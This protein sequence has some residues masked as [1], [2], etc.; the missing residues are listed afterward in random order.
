MPGCSSLG[1][2]LAKIDALEK[3]TGRAMYAADRR[4][5]GMLFVKHRTFDNGSFLSFHAPLI[6]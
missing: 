1:V 3:V 6:L 2:S 5:E 4:V